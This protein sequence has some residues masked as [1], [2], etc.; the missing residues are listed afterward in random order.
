MREPS[1]NRTAAAW[2]DEGRGG[3]CGAQAARDADL[4]RGERSIYNWLL[5]PTHHT[6]FADQAAA[7][8]RPRREVARH[9]PA[10]GRLGGV[11]DDV[12]YRGGAGDAA[13]LL[14]RLTGRKSLQG[15]HA[16]TRFQLYLFVLLGIRKFEPELVGLWDADLQ[17]MTGNIAVE[18]QQL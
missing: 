1:L 11:A 10:A 8:F 13:T 12:E 9:D 4:G 15:T 14:G 3:K 5:G 7:L 2:R 18:R 17:A 16:S 6:R